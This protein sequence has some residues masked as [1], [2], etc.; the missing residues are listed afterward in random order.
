MAGERKMQEKDNNKLRICF[1]APF[2]PPYGGI[3]NWMA[4]MCRYIDAEKK[5]EISY[6]VINTAPKKRVT[7]GRT[8]WERI[9]GGGINAYISCKQLRER[10][11]VGHFECVHLTTSGSLSL[12]RDYLLCCIAN[13][14]DVPIV[15]HIHFGRI[16]EMNMKDGIE[17]KFFKRILK[18]V[19]VVLVIDKKTFEC[20]FPLLKE[21]V[22]YIPNPIDIKKLPGITKNTEKIV[23][24]L[25]WV[26][27]EK[28]IEELLEAWEHIYVENPDWMLY[29]V[30]PYDEEYYEYL[31]QQYNLQGVEFFGEKPH[32]EAM[33]LLN[34]AS[35]FVLPSYTEGCPYSVMEAMALAKPVIATAVGN[36]PDMLYENCGIVVESKNY[37][38]IED[39]VKRLISNPYERNLFGCC[40]YGKVEKTYLVENVVQMYI[41]R[42]RNAK[43]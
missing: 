36:I 37:R 27:K 42:W 28:G 6:E 23:M 35:I 34:A 3:A 10:L 20:L 19:N 4:M 7:E 30:G 24:Y 16:P 12:I 25:G 21:R 43:S 5:G 26:I 31:K 17:W 29:I 38:E 13:R 2:P 22:S 33:K 39:A 11:L 18:K 41:S 1:V 9:V 15:Y 8:L 40:A 14:L 32:N